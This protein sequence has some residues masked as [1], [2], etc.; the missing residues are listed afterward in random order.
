MKEVKQW[1]EF[2][3]KHCQALNMTSI[4][5]IAT[6]FAKLSGL[7]CGKKVYKN[8]QN[9][10]ELTEAEQYALIEYVL[11]RRSVAQLIR[12]KTDQTCSENS[13]EDEADESIWKDLLRIEIKEKRIWK[14]LLRIIYAGK[15][16]Q[17]KYSK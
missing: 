5:E 7:I 16:I 15:N 11:T 3:T 13:S 17:D 14:R 4:T 8:Y 12:P 6:R 9:I 1:F 10:L 2:L